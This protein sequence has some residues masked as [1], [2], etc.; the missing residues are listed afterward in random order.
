MKKLLIMSLFVVGCASEHKMKEVSAPLEVKGQ[1]SS[2]EMIGLNGSGEAII[3][4]KEKAD[5]E[6]RSWIWQ[7][8]N[9]EQEV[10]ST[11]YELKRCR[12]ESS[13]VR[14]GGSGEVVELPEIDNM[15]P[16]VEV[17]EQLGLINREMIVVKESYFKDRLASERQYNETLTKMM[18]TIKKHKTKCDYALSQKRVKAGLPSE[19]T[20]GK[21]LISPDGK[22]EAVVQKHEKNLDDAFEMK[23]KREPASEPQE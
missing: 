16:T 12:E 23:A 15:K 1:I 20:Q 4:T 19:R 17:K 14:L 10:S 7:N 8:N 18:K 6:L 5:Q 13:D 21:F 22:L 9:D 3:Q 11:W 2:N